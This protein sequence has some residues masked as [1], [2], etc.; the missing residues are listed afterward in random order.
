MRNRRID[1]LKKISFDD[2]KLNVKFTIII[3]TLLSLSIGIFSSIFFDSMKDTM[4]KEN[5][6]YTTYT[7]QRSVDN[8]EDTIASVNMVTQLFSTDTEMYSILSRVYEHDEITGNEW[9]NL[10][11]TTIASLERLV[12]ANPVINGVRVYSSD[13]SIQEVM[14]I[15]YKNVR[16]QEQDWYQNDEHQGWMLDYEDHLFQSY[17]LDKDSRIASYVSDVRNTQ[18]DT[19]GVIETTIQMDDMFPSLYENNDDEW[20]CFISAN[21][22]YITGEQNQEKLSVLSGITEDD[23]DSSVKTSYIQNRGGYHMVASVYISELNGYLVFVKNMSPALANINRIQIFYVLGFIILIVLLAFAIDKIVNRLLRQLNEIL[24][25]INLVQDGD[26]QVRIPKLSNDE[27]GNLSNQLNQMLD[28]IVA[29]MKENLNRELLAKNSQIRALQNQINAHFIYNVLDSINM[30]AELDEEF[31]IADAVT[32]L[33]TMLHYSMSWN[34]GMVSV[35]NELEYIQDYVKLANLRRDYEVSLDIDMP[36]A[37]MQQYIPKMSL[38]PI[39]ENAIKYGLPDEKEANIEIIGEQ[40]GDKT[41][42]EVIDHGIGMSD[43]QVAKIRKQIAGE[44]QPDHTSEKPSQGKKGHGI[45]L[46]NV[47]DRIAIAYGDAYGLSLESKEAEYTKVTM[48]IPADTVSENTE[49]F[50]LEQG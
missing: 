28:R 37:L 5:E 19:I 20:G 29:L 22:D 43:E 1:L 41:V 3:V 2:L 10:K 25:V 40:K 17:A 24:K 9:I 47:Q 6:E 32:S 27:M 36:S 46:K 35:E 14:P 7:L 45:G 33:G 26:M 4:I 49:R 38:Q 18:G 11:R 30:M 21:G 16:I 8:L 12:N 48:T 31:E 39:I 44:I 13:D 34:N 42:I 23:S 50:V 15:L